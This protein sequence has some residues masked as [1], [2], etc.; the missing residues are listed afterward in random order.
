LAYLTMFAT[1][2]ICLRSSLTRVD[3][4]IAGSFSLKK[5]TICLPL[6]AKANLWGRSMRMMLLSTSVFQES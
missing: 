1:G 3:S 5:A 2:T 4:A 6:S